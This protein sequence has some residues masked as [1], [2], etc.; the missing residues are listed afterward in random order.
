MEINRNNIF[1]IVNKAG[2]QPDKDY[3]QNFLVEPEV[4]KKI[5]KNLNINDG[6]KV[7]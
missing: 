5:V 4:S 3:G 6:D 2:L 1:E 7:I